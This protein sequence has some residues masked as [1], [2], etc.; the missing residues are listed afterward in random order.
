MKKE[1]GKGN[2]MTALRFQ[3][4]GYIRHI[5]LP[6]GWWGGGGGRQG[7]ICR[8]LTAGWEDRGDMRDK[9]DM[10]AGYMWGTERE[11]EG[12]GGWVGRGEAYL[13]A[14]DAVRAVLFSLG[15]F[16]VLL[17]VGTFADGLH[18]H[19]RLRL[20]IQRRHLAVTTANTA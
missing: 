13:Q 1:T 16:L 4:G 17:A 6:L 18:H 19:P 14:A 15:L 2:Q 9:K 12:G 3:I 10:P 5:R 20:P 7:H 11:G 8:L